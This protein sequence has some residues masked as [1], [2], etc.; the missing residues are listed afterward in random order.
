MRGLKV[1]PLGSFVIRLGFDIIQKTTLYTGFSSSDKKS[2]HAIVHAN[3]IV[4]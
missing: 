2:V 1:I 4:F 3:F